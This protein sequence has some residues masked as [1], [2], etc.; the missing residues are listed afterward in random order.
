MKKNMTFICFIIICLFVMTGCMGKTLPDMPSDAIEFNMGTFHD[1]EHDD[2]LFGSIEYNG[3]T[4]IPYGTSNNKYEKSDIESCIGYII[5]NANSSTVIDPNN[6]N[7]RIYTLSVDPEH[8]Y[9]MDF[10]DSIKL[11]NQPTFYRAIDT[12]GKK[13]D[14]PIF[15]DSLGYEFWGEY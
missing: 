15:I 14:T 10:D 12:N 6:T 9:L 13:I 11:M 3:R 8:N 2:A 1:T 4:Y 5:Q 7:R